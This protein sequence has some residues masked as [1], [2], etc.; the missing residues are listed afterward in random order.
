MTKMRMDG[1]M[2]EAFKGLCLKVWVQ[3]GMVR[4][5]IVNGFCEC[6]ENGR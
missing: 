1:M 3:L 6:L 5:W 2:K 4:E